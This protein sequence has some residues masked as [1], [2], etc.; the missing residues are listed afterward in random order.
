MLV[1]LHVRKVFY[2]EYLINAHKHDI[3]K[4]E[5]LARMKKIFT[6]LKSCREWKALE[7]TEQ[8]DW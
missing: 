8:I 1:I 6:C 2:F 7:K 3:L 5:Y 4:N